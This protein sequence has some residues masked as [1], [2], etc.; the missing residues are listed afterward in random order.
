M[1]VPASSIAT[2]SVT[3]PTMRR[4]FSEGVVARGASGLGDDVDTG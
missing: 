1:P 4:R 3:M 2:M